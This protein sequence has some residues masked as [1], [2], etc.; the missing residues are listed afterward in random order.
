MNDI[1]GDDRENQATDG[2]QS[3]KPAWQRAH[4]ELLRLAKRRARIDRTE[5][6]WLLLAAREGTHARLGYAS[7]GEYV[8]R[9]FGY[10]PR[11]TLEKLRVAEVL[12]GLPETSRAFDE[13]AINWS[14][15]RELTRV[16]TRDTETNWLKLAIGKTARDV[17]ELVAG[18][19]PGSLPSDE[20]DPRLRR[21]VIRLEVTAE[22]LAAFR[23][24]T[25]KLRRDAGGR[26]EDDAVVLLLAR[27]VLG[28]PTDEGRASYQISL[29]V[30]ERC[31][32]GS[33]RG[34]G[35]PV[36]VE[37]EVV[38]MAA[39]DAQNIVGAST[40]AS[41][42]RSRAVDNLTHVGTEPRSDSPRATQSVPPAV[43]RRV[44]A[45][46]SGRCVV[47][48]CRHAVFVD[49]HHVDPRADGGRNEVENLVTLCGAHHR[50]V[51]RG[52]IVVECVG[53]GAFQFRHAD[54]SEYGSPKLMPTIAEARAKA[55]Q[56][57]RSLGFRET[58]SRRALE[59]V[60]KRAGN[61][62]TTESLLRAALR[63]LTDSAAA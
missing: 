29:S 24:A 21:H 40:S 61:A 15:A 5:G 10:A 30:C 33:Q 41:T 17:E 6:H 46:D 37:P 2:G 36:D 13:G 26:L 55:F 38:E 18:H 56:A 54:G 20:P 45:R 48:G 23:E 1:P 16:A 63:E 34:R 11:W 59:V 7:F 22:T 32:R 8:E 58:E 49:V 60:V 25:A 19:A 51:H 9:L 35:E 3:A 47:P 31:R 53:D 4:E 44:L 50:A 52:H 62:V 12:E 42:S 27:Y 43:R 14:A 57:L 28:G 39:C